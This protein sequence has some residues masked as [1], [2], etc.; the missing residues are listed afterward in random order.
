MDLQFKQIVGN[1]LLSKSY[2][3][4]QS[5][6]DQLT[7]LSIEYFD[8]L[9]S[10]LADYT[11]LQ[12]R[13]LPSKSDLN[14]LLKL[15]KISLNGI[16][17]EKINS[18]D[19][20]HINLIEESETSSYNEQYSITKLVPR[21]NERPNYIPSY[22]PDLPP[23]YTY[24]STPEYTETL[25]DLKKLRI[26]LVEE[27]RLTEKSLYKLIENDE[28]EW[29]EKL[30]KELSVLEPEP[31]EEVKPVENKET[32]EE[33]KFDFTKYAN[34]RRE[35][36]EKRA[37]MVENKRKQR[38]QNIFMEAEVYYSPYLTKQPTEEINK[39]FQEILHNEFKHVI[40]SIRHQTELKEERLK[41]E[42]ELKEAELEE[43]RRLNEIQFNFQQH[44][45]GSD[46]ESEEDKFDEILF[47]EKTEEVPN[48]T[49]SNEAQASEPDQ[50]QSKL[51]STE[52]QSKPQSTE[53]PSKSQSVEPQ[54]RLPTI[55][56]SASIQP[57]IDS[58][59]MEFDDIVSKKSESNDVN[60]TIN[61]GSDNF[62]KA[63]QNNENELL[64]DQNDLQLDHEL[65]AGFELSSDDDME[66]VV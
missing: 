5:F 54:S 51:Q 15:R 43:K 17:D 22:L 45:S 49:G 11:K 65:N 38:K 34:Q 18:K 30:E 37:N 31:I 50:G 10:N 47:S 8:G 56:E 41:K 2:T 19:I 16:V 39:Y 48:V 25:T 26:K 61:Q 20:K 23:D 21:I 64:P 36:L 29:K 7:E 44:Y 57:D 40:K 14:T 53:P 46:S 58:D 9:I 60:V 52:P 12:R 32:E 28:I 55:E 13:R 62:A 66:D 1:I 3:C 27:S 59:E 42:R 33:F 6:L 24:Q 63:Q 35:A 4:S